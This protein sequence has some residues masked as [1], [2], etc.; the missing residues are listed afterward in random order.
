LLIFTSQV[1][2]MAF[3]FYHALLVIPKDLREAASSSHLNA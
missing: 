2:N 3:S 1:W